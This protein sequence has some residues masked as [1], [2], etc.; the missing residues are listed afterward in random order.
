MVKPCTLCHKIT[1]AP[2]AM[3]RK[4]HPTPD[5][6]YLNVDGIQ[7]SRA[8]SQTGTRS[9]PCN[10]RGATISTNQLF[11]DPFRSRER[12]HA[13]SD[14]LRD[15]GLPVR[16]RLPQVALS[17]ADFY[18]SKELPQFPGGGSIARSILV[19]A[20]TADLAESSVSAA[21]FRVVLPSALLTVSF[22]ETMTRR[23]AVRW[24]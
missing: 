19:K 24:W 23:S 5:S 8:L 1:I 18:E 22:F 15:Q 13:I 4:E 21:C 9:R 20:G 16:H 11:I 14:V 10:I 6:K 2:V 7:S 3:T 17:A 12:G